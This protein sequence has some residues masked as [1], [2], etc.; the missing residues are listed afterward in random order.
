MKH[1]KKF[2]IFESSEQDVFVQIVD[3]I[4]RDRLSDV[5]FRTNGVYFILNNMPFSLSLKSDKDKNYQYN[6]NDQS[7]DV[8]YPDSHSIFQNDFDG[9]DSCVSFILKKS[10]IVN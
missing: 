2:K 7:I 9:I 8:S 6:I 5:K 3:K 4:G 10:K 1:L